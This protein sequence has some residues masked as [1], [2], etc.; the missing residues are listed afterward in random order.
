MREATKTPMT[1]LKELRAS[2]AEMRETLHTTIVVVAWVL[3]QS[4]LYGRV[5]ERKPLFEK[6]Q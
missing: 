4:K 2:A 1:P 6:A 3:H 5:A